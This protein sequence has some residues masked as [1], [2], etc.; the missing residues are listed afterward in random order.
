MR[1]IR[2]KKLTLLCLAIAIALT[3]GSFA[4][5]SDPDV[6]PVRLSLVFD[7]IEDTDDMCI[8]IHPTDPSLST[9]IAADKAADY[10]VVYDL[11]G[12]TLQAIQLER[13]DAGSEQA[14][15]IDLRYGIALGDEIVDVVALNQRAPSQGKGM[16]IYKIDP[17]TRLLTRIDTGLALDHSNYGMCLYKSRVSGKLYYF[18]TAKAHGVEQYELVDNGQGQLEPVLVRSWA[19]K[20]CEGAVADDELGY[21][22]ICEEATGVFRYGAEPDA[23]IEG[24][25]VVATGREEGDFEKDTEGITLYYAPEGGYMIV[26]SQGSNSFFVYDRLPPHAYVKT[27]RLEGVSETDGVDV[28]NVNLGSDFPSGLFVCHSDGNPAIAVVA[29]F[30]DLGLEIDTS[31]DP[32]TGTYN[33]DE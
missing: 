14:G 2:N 9:I 21:V 17:E 30:E 18:A 29:A 26:S 11:S 8:W 27:F 1:S 10:V 25:L 20:K 28:T 23:S 33:T 5:M 31:Y 7:G 24:T 13:N 4:T 3:A 32:R 6:V 12:N 15:N 19:Q 22:Y 16:R